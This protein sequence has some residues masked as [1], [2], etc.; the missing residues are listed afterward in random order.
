MKEYYDFG[1][2]IKRKRLTLNMRM[3]DVASMAN[4]SRTTLWSIENNKYNYSVESLLKVIQILGIQ[5]V[6]D[7][8][9]TKG[10]RKRASRINT[11]LD[12]EKNIFIVL[13]VQQYA[14][15][16]NKSSFDT[17]Q[18]LS[19]NRILNDLLDDY[20]DLHGMSSE[21]INDYINKLLDEKPLGEQKLFG[22][23]TG[24]KAKI[25]VEVVEMIAR[26]YSLPLDIARE[27][28]YSSSVIDKIDE[29]IESYKDS[30]Q[31]FFDIFKE[32]HQKSPY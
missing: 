7:E 21:W 32:K 30:P 22:K 16:I 13:S 27:V 29:E 4:I 9:G 14:S 20:E 6:I 2:Y 19:A 12:K 10:P 23:N 17:Y 11:V 3:D 25:I 31:H 5:L 18:M 15:A 8:V 28:L 26:K 1:R 24:I